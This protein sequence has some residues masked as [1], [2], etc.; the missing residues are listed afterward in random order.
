[1]VR[2]ALAAAVG[3]IAGLALI[4]APA[5]AT[6]GSVTRIRFTLDA[7]QMQAW[8]NGVVVTAT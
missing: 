2:K 5:A 1:M 8:T 7:A 3:V 6:S 4:S